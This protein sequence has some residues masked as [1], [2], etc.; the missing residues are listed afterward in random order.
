MNRIRRTV[1][2]ALAATVVAA[3]ANATLVDVTWTGMIWSGNDRTGI[4]GGVRGEDF[5]LAGFEY[6]AV[7]RFDTD[8]GS[9]TGDATREEVVGGTSY[10]TIASP[11]IS[12]SMTINGV[13]VSVGSDVAGS[14]LRRSEAANGGFAGAGVLQTLVIASSDTPPGVDEVFHR[15]LRNDDQLLLPVS[16][17]VPYARIFGAGDIATNSNFQKFDGGDLVAANLE[18]T[19]ISVVAVPEPSIQALVITV[20]GVLGGWSRFRSRTI[21]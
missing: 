4:F 11:A 1:T 16:L 19:S 6:T 7:H 18:P 21:R 3:V 2:L 13:T 8:L 20:F 12:T 14:Y 9:F 17:T 10:G 15:V 5:N